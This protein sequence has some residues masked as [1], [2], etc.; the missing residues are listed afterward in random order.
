MKEIWKMIEGYDTYKISNFGNILS[1][2]SNGEWKL[3]KTYITKCGYVYVNLYQKGK[4]QNKSIHSLVAKAF[5]DGWFPGAE[6]N[7]KDL[8]KLNNH[9][10]N[11]EWV[12]HS[13]NQQHQIMMRKKQRVKKF[14]QKCGKELAN[15]TKGN[16]CFSCLKQYNRK[17]NWPSKVQLS[18]DLKYSFLP[19]LGEKYGYSYR[20]MR[21]ICEAYNLPTNKKDII[22]YREQFGIYQEPKI[23]KRKP[24]KERY[25]FYEVDNNSMT[26]NG[27]SIY[28]GLDSKRIGRYTK[29][30]TYEETIQYIKYWLNKVN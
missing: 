27:W 17:K 4:S 21:K 16:L 29:K 5:V 28:L 25:T 6:V 11:L 9:A 8:N 12:T 15:R 14:C 2:S 23:K 7:H 13:E 20:N 10:D 26:A 19:E 18:E 22:L 1:L 24:L 30:H 3:R